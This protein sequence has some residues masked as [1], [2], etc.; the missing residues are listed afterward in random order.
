[1]TLYCHDDTVEAILVVHARCSPRYTQF[2]GSTRDNDQT[3]RRDSSHVNAQF[4]VATT[5][6][7]DKVNV[8]HTHVPAEGGVRLYVMFAKLVTSTRTVP[9]ASKAPAGSVV[10]VLL[11]VPPR[12]TVSACHES[13]PTP[14]YAAPP[15]LTRGMVVAGTST[16]MAAIA[17]ALKCICTPLLTCSHDQR[18]RA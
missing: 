11:Y 2:E 13:P 8:V 5:T 4:C 10:A 14:V 6:A 15:Q 18:T 1:M 7:S 12:G 3:F 9:Y 16:I 17:N